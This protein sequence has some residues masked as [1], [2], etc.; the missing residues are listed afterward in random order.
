[1][2]LLLRDKR[3]PKRDHYRVLGCG[4][5]LPRVAVLRSC[6]HPGNRKRPK[7]HAIIDEWKSSQFPPGVLKED[8]KALSG[9]M[10][11]LA[12]A[13]ESESPELKQTALFSLVCLGASVLLD[14]AVILE[15]EL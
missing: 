11:S 6:G 3:P 12:A 15:E 9:W 5:L 13:V 4:H 14:F 7:G 10:R 1:M 2:A 8:F